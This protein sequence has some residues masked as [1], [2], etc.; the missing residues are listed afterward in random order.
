MY[1]I[2]FSDWGLVLQFQGRITDE[3]IHDWLGDIRQLAGGFEGAFGAVVDLRKAEPDSPV[4]SAS[5]LRGLVT[6][7]RAGMVRAV[8]VVSQVDSSWAIS[9]A[10]SSLPGLRFVQADPD[11]R[12]QR[13]AYRWVQSADAPPVSGNKTGMSRRATP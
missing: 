7:K 1:S 11:D 2:Q 13:Q 12:W 6:L 8:A 5:V 4:V 10:P 3:I 9:D